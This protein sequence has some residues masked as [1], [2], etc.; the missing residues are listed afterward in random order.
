MN[1]KYYVCMITKT[2]KTILFAS[3]IVAM[4]IPEAFAMQ[5]NMINDRQFG[6]MVLPETTINESTMILR[7]SKATSFNPI[8]FEHSYS[9][10]IPDRNNRGHTTFV[11]AFNN[12]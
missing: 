7:D 12:Y 4:I 3:L 9:D 1:I 11:M 2:I 6:S 8:H 5:H 10:K